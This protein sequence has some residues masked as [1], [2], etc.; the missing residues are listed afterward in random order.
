[1]E[2]DVF[3]FVSNVDVVGSELQ[4]FIKKVNRD[5]GI[6][7]DY[8]KSNECEFFFVFYVIKLVEDSFSVFL[9]I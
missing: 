7:I 6:K 3:F 8:I 9:L 5:R 4:C 1:M 2:N